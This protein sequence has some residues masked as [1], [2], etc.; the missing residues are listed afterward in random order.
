M[1]NIII[2]SKDRAC[3]LDLLLSSMQRFFREWSEQQVSVLYAAS[4]DAFAAGYE[5]LRALHPHAHYLRETS[6]QDDLIRLFLD[7]KRPFTSFLVDDDIFIDHL[8]LDSVEFHRFASDRRVLALSGR[9]CP[10]LD[11]FYMKDVT[12][13][14][15][16]FGPDR[17]WRWKGL[18]GDWGYPMSVSGLH[19]FRTDDLYTPVVETP[20][21][22]PN[23][24]EGRALLKHPPRRPL[25]IC[26][27]EAKVFCVAVN[28]VQTV[29]QNRHAD[30]YPVERLN[31]LFLDGRRLSCA[32]H[33]LIRRRSAHGELEYEWTIPA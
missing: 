12:V 8:T 17:T 27:A 24:F 20:Y 9:M 22:N 32:N 29:N 3:Q 13:R 4:D 2:F 11:Y 14:P 15:P 19:I 25:M 6:F 18:A 7:F 30:S 28:K 26:Y 21:T 31:T 16:R 33:H 5:R 23:T 10:R 1:I